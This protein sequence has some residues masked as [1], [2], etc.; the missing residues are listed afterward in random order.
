M[1]KTKHDLA[2][3]VKNEINEHLKDSKVCLNLGDITTIYEIIINNLI[4]H[5]KKDGAA[6]FPGLGTLERH[7]IPSRSYDFGEGRKGVSDPH[8]KL[9]FYV[10]PKFK[11][12]SE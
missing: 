4:E 9:E 10:K 1:I 11:R 8:E 6:V 2:K 7:T 3:A 5:A 12:L